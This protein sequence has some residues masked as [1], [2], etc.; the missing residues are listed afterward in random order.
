[1]SSDFICLTETWI[2]RELCNNLDLID[3]QWY[4][5]QRCN[6]YDG[7]SALTQMLKEQSHG[8]V[9]V[10]ARKDRVFSR[11]NIPITNLEYIAFQKFL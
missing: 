5:Q 6:S 9:A 11:L 3:F 1:M 10:C 7:S 8:G 2:D 4:H